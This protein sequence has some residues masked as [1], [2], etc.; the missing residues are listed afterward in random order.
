MSVSA[1]LDDIKHSSNIIAVN[2]QTDKDLEEEEKLIDYFFDLL[3][4]YQSPT[5]TPEEEFDK[6]GK[7]L[8]GPTKIKKESIH[9][10]RRKANNHSLKR[11]SKGKRD[12]W[13]PEEDAQLIALYQQYGQQ[14]SKIASLMKNRTGKRVRERYLN[15]LRPDI[16]HEDWTKEEEKL[17]IELGEKYGTKW[18]KIASHLPGRTEIQ[19][20]NKFYWDKNRKKSVPQKA[21]IKEFFTSSQE[22]LETCA[23]I[24][25]F[26]KNTHTRVKSSF[27]K[28]S[29]DT[30]DVYFQA[31]VQYVNQKNEQVLVEN[32]RELT[33]KLE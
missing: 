23:T 28:I 5:E 21:P 11:D 25:N 31:D 22:N 18:S 6:S 33:W 2:T 12:N 16:N 17:L 26:P 24:A 14:W 3:E 20:K 1:S 15:I 13:K 4:T 10:T 30:V 9:Y 8:K 7:I 29:G 19:V 27:S 32:F